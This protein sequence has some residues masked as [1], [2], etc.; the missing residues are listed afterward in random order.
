MM[1]VNLNTHQSSADIGNTTFST[2]SII[3]FNDVKVRDTKDPCPQCHA[4]LSLYV[5]KIK[6]TGI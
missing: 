1:F 2:L 6:F 4:A 3:K 5:V